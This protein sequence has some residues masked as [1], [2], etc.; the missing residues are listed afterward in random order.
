MNAASN[1]V[2]RSIIM[3]AASSL[4]RGRAIDASSA[5][6]VVL[7]IDS[8]RDL[9]KPTDPQAFAGGRFQAAAAG[10]TIAWE[11]LAKGMNPMNYQALQRRVKELESERDELKRQLRQFTEDAPTCVGGD[12][13]QVCTKDADCA[14]S[15][16]MA[17]EED[18]ALHNGAMAVAAAMS[19]RPGMAQR[20][21]DPTIVVVIAQAIAAIFG[22]CPAKNEPAQLI[23]R[24]RR[25]NFRDRLLVNRRV[26]QS[27]SR[28]DWNSYGPD[29]VDSIF[30][31]GAEQTTNQ[32]A[33]IVGAVD[34]DPDLID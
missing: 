16:M 6:E 21:F 32:I 7:S 29:V 13:N 10:F 25:A 20:A 3:I 18:D 12:C 17:V 28:R 27:M 30:E 4:N 23:E 9:S 5:A 34:A 33:R 24:A 2:D 1:E 11:V 8:D 19:R 15:V 22:N 26:R 14:G 31:A